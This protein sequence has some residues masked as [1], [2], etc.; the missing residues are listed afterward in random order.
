MRTAGSQVSATVTPPLY[1]K[2]N[3]LADGNGVSISH[4][5]KLAIAAYVG[6]TDRLRRDGFKVDGEAA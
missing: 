6:D 2:L 4:V 5:I 3:K 1:E